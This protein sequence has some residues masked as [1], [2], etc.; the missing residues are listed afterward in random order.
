MNRS[1]D[2]VPIQSGG[3]IMRG[4]L[5]IFSQVRQAKQRGQAAHAGVTLSGP[6]MTCR[7]GAL[8]LSIRDTK[9]KRG[10]GGFV[11]SSFQPRGKTASQ[12]HQSERMSYC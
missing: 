10:G 7:S 5:Y 12:K 4:L 1:S 2:V 3:S 11:R 8:F 6:P 9:K